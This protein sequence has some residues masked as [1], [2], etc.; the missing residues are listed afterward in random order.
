M[1][2]LRSFIQ[3][4]PGN[5]RNIKLR[6]SFVVFDGYNIIVELYVNSTL[7]TQYNGEL[8]AFDVIIE[9]F[10]SNLQKCELEPI[11]VFDGIREVCYL[12]CGTY[13]VE[14]LQHIIVIYNMVKVIIS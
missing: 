1:L 13:Q 3:R 9:K 7:L 10:L 8:Y 11:F 2:G 6:K 5:F 4:E 12:K 14:V